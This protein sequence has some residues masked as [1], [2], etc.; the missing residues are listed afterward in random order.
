[1][2]Y[3]ENYQI[4]CEEMDKKL[5]EHLN[6][7]LTW[8]EFNHIRNAGSLMMLE[9]YSKSVFYVQNKKDA[10]DILIEFSKVKR[11]VDYIQ[12]FRNNAEKNSIYFHADFYSSILKKGNCLD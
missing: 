4:I 6:R 9:S 3:A 8:Q 10:E 1:M 2:N 5:E 12:Q 11:L 7:K